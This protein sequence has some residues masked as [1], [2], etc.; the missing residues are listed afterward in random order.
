MNRWSI[1]IKPSIPQHLFLHHFFYEKVDPTAQ[2]T[3]IDKMELMV[4]R[5]IYTSFLKKEWGF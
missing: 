4:G 3:V 2:Q 1:Q 5:L